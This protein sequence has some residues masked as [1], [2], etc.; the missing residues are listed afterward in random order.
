MPQGSPSPFSA[1][2]PSWG[3]QGSPMQP[4]QTPRKSGLGKMVV[5]LVV[6]V[7]LGTA[8]YFGWRYFGPDAGQSAITT[9]P[10]N[11]TVTYAGIAL[12]VQQVQQSQRFID[13]PNTG[14]SGMVRL[15]MQG[16]NTGSAPVNLVYTNIARLVLPG[17][18][19]VTPT[20]VKSNVSLVPGTTQTSIVDFAV[21][22]NIKFGQLV[23]RVGAVEEAQMDIPLTGQA[24]LAAYAPKTTPINKKL[25]Y[26]GLNWT[27]ASASSQ[28]S[29]D[30]QQASK[31]MR[32][33]TV[34]FAIDNPLVQT[35]IPGSPYDYMRLQVGSTSLAPVTS[36]LPTSFEAG[37][38]GKTGM[39]TFLAP[40][41][42]AI[43]TLVLL[44]QNGFNQRTA[45]IQF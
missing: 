34:T 3:Q 13:D 38:K 36:T 30:T 21:P 19:V 10:I 17:G 25:E 31:G 22:S 5:V 29:L 6:L 41:N 18:K 44:P 9:T 8:G 33:V 40:Q 7:L 1:Q 2:Q 43:L 14:T 42:A 16:K 35:A 20:Y 27:I 37:A 39:V 45:N 12:T 32:Y 15:S 11:A 4:L 28:L 23:L 26:Q 24:D